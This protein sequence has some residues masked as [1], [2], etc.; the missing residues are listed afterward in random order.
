MK[1]FASVALLLGLLGVGWAHAASRYEE[2]A[3]ELVEEVEGMELRRYADTV[4]AETVM[5]SGR[6]DGFRVLA[7]YIFGGN[8]EQASIAMTVPVT[9][10]SSEAGRVMRFTMPS[11]YQLDTLPEP[12]DG[13]VELVEVP[14][15][16]MLA[17]RF[18]G[19]MTAQLEAEHTAELLAG[20]ERAGLEVLG[21]PLLAQ[22]NQP[23]IPGPLRRNEVLVR[24]KASR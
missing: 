17:L 21:E 3:W 8:E 24:V 13:R 4:Q 12:A 10:Q 18:S 14:G 20:A 9:T 11:A 6:N 15:G 22:Y 19:R 7:G 23:W 16:E 1:M 2:P 5:T